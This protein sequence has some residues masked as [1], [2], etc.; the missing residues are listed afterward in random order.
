MSGVNVI[1]YLLANNAP[2]VAVIPATRILLGDAPAGTPRP[3]VLVSQVDS[4]PYNLIKLNEPNKLHTDRVQVSWFFNAARGN[5]SGTGHAGLTAMSRLVLTACA[6][7]RGT[8]A[9]VFVNSIKPESEGP[10]L[11]T[12]DGYSRSRDFLVTWV[13]D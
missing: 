8:I 12:E 2:V 4:V 3:F 5:P 9:G 7:Q 11:P 10:D 1:R 13:G 6:S